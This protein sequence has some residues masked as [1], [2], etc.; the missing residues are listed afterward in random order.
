MSR[1]SHDIKFWGVRGSIATDDPDKTHFGGN[2][3]CVEVSPNDD[4][5]IIF[6]SGSG[7]RSLGNRIA[8]EHDSD[9][10]INLFLS[11]THWD[12][13]LGFPFFAPIHQPFAKI[14]IHGPRR[15]GVSLEKSVLGLFQSPYFPLN[16]DDIQAEINFKELDTG[17]VKLSEDVTMFSNPHPHPNGALGYRL[18]M[19]AQSVVFITDIEHTKDNLVESVVN[20]SR[21]ADILIHD[22]HFSAEELPAHKTWGHSSWE[23]CTAIAN[24]AGVKQLY[25]FHFSPNYSDDDVNAMVD[26]ARADFANTAAAHQGLSVTLPAK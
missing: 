22:S 1:N 26:R 12:H 17:S 21:D 14:N 9:Y 15:T 23:T 10:E 13:I 2:T 4:S 24:E 6:D 19:G 5:I 7:I 16:P 25:L 11:H 18:E 20:L 8:E 3:S